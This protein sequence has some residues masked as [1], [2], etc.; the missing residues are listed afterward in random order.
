MRKKL[1][2]A[3]VVVLILLAAAV[4]VLIYLENRP[5]ETPDETKPGA[6]E[7]QGVP[8]E[9]ETEKEAEEVTVGISLPTEN[10]DEVGPDYT[11]SENDT[12]PPETAAPAEPGAT[13]DPD[14]NE[15]PEMPA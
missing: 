5:G 12:T 2:A 9:N 15:T 7:T 1:I 11:W 6:S 14:E 8:S 4:G 13:Q 3:I 10:P